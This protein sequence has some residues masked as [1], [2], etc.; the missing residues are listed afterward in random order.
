MNPRTASFPRQ[1]EPAFARTRV[2]PRRTLRRIPPGRPPARRF[3]WS[4]IRLGSIA[5]VPVEIHTSC[6]IYPAGFLLCLA[7]TGHAARSMHMSQLGLAI[8]LEGFLA[9]LWGCLLVHEFA[10]VFA[11]RHCG[12]DTERVVILPVGAA[13]LMRKP[14]F[15][16]REFWVA[17]AGPAASL[18]LAGAFWLLAE[19]LPPIDS[20][21]GRSAILMLL[22]AG[23]SINV[24]IAIFN[25]LP[26]FP[27]DGGRMLRSLLAMTIGLVTRHPRRHA[28]G[29][30][31]LIVVRF[32]N[33]L[34]VTGAIAFTII[35]SHMWMH[36]VLFPLLLAAGEVERRVER[37][38]RLGIED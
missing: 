6:L 30:A 23:C 21:A 24:V 11:A 26:C 35:K 17:F 28:F 37:E 25:L 20:P 5:A 27:M 31:T 10:H 4:A 38:D 12:I 14:L 3:S 13:A 22:E 9:L 34:I 33:P 32:V 18:A 16:T 19:F 29:L 1:T 36:L 7:F 8:L 2:R 15:D